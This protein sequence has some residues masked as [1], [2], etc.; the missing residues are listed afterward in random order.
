MTQNLSTYTLIN[1]V[2]DYNKYLNEERKIY[3]RKEVNY[4][5][6]FSYQLW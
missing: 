3:I 4:Y 6:D 5:E 1:Q 2:E